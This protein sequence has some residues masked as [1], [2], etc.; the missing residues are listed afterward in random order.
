MQRFTVI[1]ASEADGFVAVVPALP[2]A[3][4]QGESRAEALRN[5]AEAINGWVEAARAAG[6]PVPRESVETIAAKVTEV[7]RY[8]DELGLTRIL[9]MATA[10]AA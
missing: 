8:R 10:S 4:S 1:L 9:E 7:L 5:I 6:E 2:G 3:A